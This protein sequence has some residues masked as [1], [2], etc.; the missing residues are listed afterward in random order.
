MPRRCDPILIL[1]LSTG[2]TGYIGGDVFFDFN[3]AH[4]DWEYSV[5]TRTKEKGA[6][7]SSKYP[8]ARIVIGDLDSSDLIAEET[9]NAD[10]VLRT[11]RPPPSHSIHKMTNHLRLRRLRSRRLR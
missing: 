3:Q 7:V 6:Q 11:S 1:M 2:A 4:P 5:L 10:I 8:K 9:K